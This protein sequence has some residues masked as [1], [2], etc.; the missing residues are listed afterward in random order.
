MLGYL[1]MVEYKKGY[2]NKV[3]DAL[4]RR[5]DP[6]YEASVSPSVSASHPTLFLILFPCPS[7][8]EELK[9]SYEQNLELQ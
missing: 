5:S 2:E 6:S 7:W 4:S 1:F 8:I 9:D 3:A